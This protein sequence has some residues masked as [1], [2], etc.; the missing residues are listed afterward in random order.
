M[1]APPTSQAHDQQ[2]YQ[3]FRAVDTD[4][5]G[6][7]DVT[8]LQQA[9]AK[10]S[11][12]FSLST[13]AQM[14]RLHARNNTRTIDYNEFCELHG[15]IT[16]I[17]KSFHHFDTDRSN[18]LNHEEAFEALRHAGLDFPRQAFDTLFVTFDPDNDSHLSMTEY[19]A[20]SV[21]LKSCE[22]TWQAFGGPS[23]GKIELDWAQWVYAAANTR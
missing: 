10:G 4:G 2:L 6:S 19:L 22:L 17:Q 1:Q 13:C 3:W 8:E 5:S 21:F 18:T 14:I 23:R 20:L 16:G 7:I 9:L 11:M 15:F 12:H